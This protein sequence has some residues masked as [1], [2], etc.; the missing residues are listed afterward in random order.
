MTSGK[1]FTDG[2]SKSTAWFP[3]AYEVTVVIAMQS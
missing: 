3:Y 2:R 1:R